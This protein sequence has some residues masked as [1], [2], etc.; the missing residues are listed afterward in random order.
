MPLISTSFPNLNGG[1]S[2]QPPSQ[3][4]DNQC[5]AQENA[6]PQVIGGLTKRPPTEFVGE[7]KK[8][9]GA[10]TKLGGDFIH[11]IQRDE[12]E[13]YILGIETDG[14]IYVWDLDGVHQL[15]YTP[16]GTNT[17][18]YLSDSAL[19]KPNETL[20][21]VTIGDLTWIVNT[22]K[23]V[24]MTSSLSPYSRNQVTAPNEALLWIKTSGQGVRF[25]VEVKVGAAAAQTVEVEYNA[26]EIHLGQGSGQHVLDPAIPSTADFAELLTNATGTPPDGFTVTGTTLDAMTDVTATRVGS[27]ISISATQ[28]FQI[29]VEDSFGQSA[30]TLIKGTATNFDELPGIAR[31]NQI[32]LV[33]GNP[34]AEVDDYYV[35][36]ETNGG[37][38]FG[39]GLWV[40]TVGPGI[41]YEFDAS[42]MPH[43]LVRQ[44]NGSWVIKSADGQPPVSGGDPA[45]GTRWQDYRFA[46][47]AAGS[48]LTNPLPS[49]VDSYISDITYFKGRLAI[50]SGE[51]VA[52]SEA[53]EFFNFFRT[54]VTQLLDS[55]VIDV[56]VGGTAVNNLKRAVDFSD[57]LL[58]FSERT[59]FVLQGEPILT[60]LTA[61]VTRATSFNAATSAAPAPAGS[62]LFFPFSRGQYSGIREFYK[63]NEN[64][65]NFDAVESSLQVPKYIRGTIR[66]LTSSNHEDM[67]VVLAQPL[68]KLYCYKFFGG[69][70][71]RIQSAWFDMTIEE[72][73]I[74][75]AEFLQD[76]LFLVT[77]RGNRSYI[78]RMDVQTG[79]TDPDSDYVTYLDYRTRITVESG[80]QAILGDELVSNGTFDSGTQGWTP[81]AGAT[82]SLMLGAL[83]L[84]LP[85][86]PA[87]LFD[88]GEDGGWW[89]PQD[90]STMFEDSAA[91]IQSSLNGPVSYIADKSGNENHLTQ[92]V[93]A[94]AVSLRQDS[95]R[96]RLYNDS[97]ADYLEFTNPAA[98]GEVALATEFGVLHCGINTPAAVSEIP[99]STHRTAY[100]SAYSIYRYL[101]GAVWR[102]EPFTP[103]EKGRLYGWFDAN[104]QLPQGNLVFA[105]QTSLANRFRGT[106]W[107]KWVQTIDTTSVTT[108]SG[109]FYGCTALEYI[110]DWDLSNCTNYQEMFYVCSRLQTV[111]NVTFGAPG[112]GSSVYRMFN[113]CTSLDALPEIDLSNVSRVDSYAGSCLNVTHIPAINA[114]NATL[115]TS[116]FTS[117][118]NVVTVTSF[119]T[120]SATNLSNTFYNMPKVEGVFPTLNVPNCVNFYRLLRGCAKIT[121]INL[122]NFIGSSAA[123]C[124]EMFYG[125][126]SLANVPAGMFDLCLA[127]NFL[128]AFY[129]CGLT[130]ASVDNILISLDNAGQSGGTIQLN[131]GTSAAPSA[132]GQTAKANLQA[133][134]W[135]VVTN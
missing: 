87:A 125:C 3:R 53:G 135:T 86:D 43:I 17:L 91:T 68:N 48:D 45:M 128:N 31:N 132:A 18:S 117:C 56:G 1:V 74:V 77:Q 4:L 131:G 111:S 122:T 80:S 89:D 112:T 116:A 22:T 52:L 104:T 20:R 123:D 33:E 126:S 98:D 69:Q 94:S 90:L 34:E 67:L 9:G 21:V 40:E 8:S 115:W 46:D 114:G 36:F 5:E 64:D 108:A 24:Q 49:F 92:P 6:I 59:Q 70:Q 95:G 88:N 62:T 130:Q 44:P 121:H 65:L 51:N 58:L 79:L 39:N 19:Q 38:D 10:A 133:R 16:D 14:S 78:E 2:Q 83:R 37:V 27:V 134:G 25:K 99:W 26:P 42:T 82:N 47:R 103:T 54:T 118:L 105:G 102:D 129:A 106:L 28:D 101:Y 97:N 63:V 73:E 30:H 107:L 7:L 127:K 13:K 32:V 57:R 100:N 72:A 110:G 41:K 76:S 55:A 29:T 84:E 35:K 23:K 50:T 113:G 81:S 85:W 93:P 12:N 15:L 124:R 61:T 120:S 11:F 119:D 96:Y 66:K 71:N 75:N 60:P 109:A